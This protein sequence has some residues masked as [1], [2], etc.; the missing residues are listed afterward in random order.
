M[1]RMGQEEID[2]LAKVVRGKNLFRV[3]SP[4]L[5]VETFEKEWAQKIEARF[6]LCVNGGTSALISS[7]KISMFLKKEVVASV[8]TPYNRLSELFRM[9]GELKIA[10]ESNKFTES[11]K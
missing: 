5:E 1:Y 9:A 3:D 10:E 7:P 6:A 11:V 8:S 2:E 4:Y